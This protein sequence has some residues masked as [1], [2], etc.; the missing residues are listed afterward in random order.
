VNDFKSFPRVLPLI[1][2]ILQAISSVH[3]HLLE[4]ISFPTKASQFHFRASLIILLSLM[5]NSLNFPESFLLKFSL[6][7]IIP[8]LFPLTAIHSATP[9]FPS[10]SIKHSFILSFLFLPFLSL[11]DSP[12]P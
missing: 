9:Q 7:A 6:I 10:P 5:P 8:V 4:S 2:T 3:Q 12:S 1:S 11:K